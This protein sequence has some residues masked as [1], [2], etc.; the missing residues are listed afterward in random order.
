M[1]TRP[2]WLTTPRSEMVRVLE[3]QGTWA[4]SDRGLTLGGTKR[5]KSDASIALANGQRRI[6]SYC[7]YCQKCRTTAMLET[8]SWWGRKKK[9]TIMEKDHVRST[10]VYKI[11]SDWFGSFQIDLSK[12]CTQL[13]RTDWLVDSGRHG[14]ILAVDCLRIC[15]GSKGTFAGDLPLDVWIFQVSGAWKE[16]E[17]YERVKRVLK[18]WCKRW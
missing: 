6:I 17:R 18:E 16:Y 9:R 10:S 11:D 5:S 13:N 12:W 1:W 2:R 7:S 3:N 15:S 14:R 4:L 8:W